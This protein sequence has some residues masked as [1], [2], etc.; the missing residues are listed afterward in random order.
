[1]ISAIGAIIGALC[2]IVIGF[3][4][5]FNLR[6]DTKLSCAIMGAFSIG[7]VVFGVVVL[8]SVVQWLTT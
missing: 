2:S 1:M 5:F 7:S 3:W 4:A 8:W 6:T